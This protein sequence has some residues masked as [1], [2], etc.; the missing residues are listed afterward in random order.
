MRMWVC[1]LL[2]L[3][4]PLESVREWMRVGA[5]FVLRLV[6]QDISKLRVA[7]FFRGREDVVKQIVHHGTMVW[8]WKLNRR[9]IRGLV[10][11]HDVGMVGG[12]LSVVVSRDAQ[13]G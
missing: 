12:R 8:G 4:Y 2:L 7:V 6:F 10:I 13:N 5:T 3:L 1:L 9:L 11:A